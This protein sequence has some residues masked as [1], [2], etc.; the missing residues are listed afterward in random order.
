[1]QFKDL[2]KVGE[3]PGGTVPGGLFEDQQGTVWLVKFPAHAIQAQNEVLAAKL[4]QAAG[5]RVPHLE[6]V[7]HEDSR[8][9]AS[10]MESLTQ[11]RLDR[12]LQGLMEGFVIDAWLANWD[13]VGLEYDNVLADGDFAVRVDLGGALLFRAQGQPKGKA[14]GPVVFEAMSLLDPRVN[15]QSASVFQ[16]LTEEDFFAG[17]V[18]LKA[19]SDALIKQLTEECGIPEIISDVLI[20]RKEFLL[21]SQDAFSDIKVH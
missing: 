8:Y 13:V 3:K 20:Q 7:Y 16:Q 9:V 1:M 2:K 11:R 14:F 12:R 6:L 18:M 21:S 19:V 5:V 4:Y 15:R 17:T 10:K